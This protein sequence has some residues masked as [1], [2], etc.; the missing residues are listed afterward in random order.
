METAFQIFDDDPTR[1]RI[2]RFERE[3]KRR[4]RR[5][6]PLTSLCLYLEA[7]SRRRRRRRRCKIEPQ[8]SP[9]QNRSCETLPVED[10]QTSSPFL[11][12]PLTLVLLVVLE[13]LLY[14]S[15]PTTATPRHHARRLQICSDLWLED[16]TVV[17]RC[18]PDR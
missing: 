4:L 9:F 18:N 14:S 7:H 16:P 15:P 8:T 12:H 1:E 5:T 17:W 2:C 6:L 3:G 10:E 13:T 11:L